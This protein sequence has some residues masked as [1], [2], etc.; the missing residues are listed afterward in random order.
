MDQLH[1][2]GEPGSCASGSGAGGGDC[3]S[4][5]EVAR[6]AF[7]GRRTE[8]RRVGECG[9]AVAVLRGEGSEVVDT[10]GCGVRREAAADGDRQ[11]Q[12][13]T[14]APAVC[15]LSVPNGTTIGSCP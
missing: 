5:S 13:V 6:A 9:G 2:I 10:G 8:A 14:T 15:G 4:A 7:I 12:Q 1:R 3:D 11:A